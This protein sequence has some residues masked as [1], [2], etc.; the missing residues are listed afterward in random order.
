M[1]N[2]KWTQIFM[3]YLY[4]ITEQSC[5]SYNDLEFYFGGGLFDCQSGHQL[6]W[7]TFSVIS[8]SL[9]NQIPW[10]YFHLATTTSFKILSNLLFIN[11]IIGRHYL[12]SIL[13]ASLNIKPASCPP[14][15]I[16]L[17]IAILIILGRESMLMHDISRYI[18][19]NAEYR[20][21]LDIKLLRG[22]SVS[23]SCWK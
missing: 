3:I 23:T 8:L 6:F 22:V 9:S 20:I 17:R 12:V 5:C 10:E 4:R 2:V 11:L 13:T 18:L 14:N 7:M 21:D 1:R 15:E 16:L 19:H